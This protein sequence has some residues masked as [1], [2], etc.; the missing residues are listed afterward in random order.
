MTKRN[1]KTKG[2]LQSANAITDTEM[3]QERT[4][5]KNKKVEKARP[6]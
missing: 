3:A 4:V 1:R 2:G 6:R 5:D